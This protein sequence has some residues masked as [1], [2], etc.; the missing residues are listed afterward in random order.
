MATDLRGSMA[1]VAVALGSDALA[2][3]FGQDSRSLAEDGW[4]RP[5]SSGAVTGRKC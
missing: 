3:F 2:I 5:W 4:A 1:I